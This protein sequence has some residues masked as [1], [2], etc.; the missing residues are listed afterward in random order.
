MSGA[1]G[2]N[3]EAMYPDIQYFV[4][5]KCTKDWQI[6]ESR[7][8][9]IDLTYVLDG[10]A[11]YYVEGHA[12]PVREGDFIC[13]PK[14][15]LRKARI[16]SARPM[17]AYAVNLT[18]HEFESK[19]EVVLPFPV[20]CHIGYHGELEYLF[21]K[22]N[23]EWT[24]KPHGFQIKARGLMLLILSDLFRI[25]VYDNHTMNWHPAVKKTIQ[26]IQ[27]HYHEPVKV[28]EIARNVGLNASYLSGLFKKCVGQPL[29]SY[30]NCYRV[31]QA[32]NLLLSGEFSVT[33]VAESCGF[34][35][36]YHFSKLF[37]K[38]K[39]YPPSRAKRMP[40]ET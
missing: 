12:Y 4:Y 30:L 2:T 29:Y 15:S 34:K 20:H 27:L 5:R 7:I 23:D 6:A 9:F 25:L 32:E 33:E 24:S 28:A 36:V 13:I 21:R 38:L 17:T 40:T 31:N 10:E 37:K 1:E 19:R 35:D 18:I 14:G 3:V 11:T 8:E 16:E 39:G 22:L 26:Y